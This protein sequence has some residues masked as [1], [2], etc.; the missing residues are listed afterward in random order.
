MKKFHHARLSIIAVVLGLS[1]ASTL[2]PVSA[3]ADTPAAD[4]KASTDVLRPEISKPLIAAKA[5]FDAKNI[6]D[7]IA[8]IA[9]ADAV[10]N[11]TPFEIFAVERTRGEYYMAAGDKPKAIKAF[12]AV[13]ASNYLKRADQLNMTQLI[14][15][16]DFQISDYPSTILWMNRYIKD[17]GTDPRAQDI[18]NKAHF[19]NKDYAEAY[20]GVN[21]QVQ[22]EIAAGV[23]PSEQNLGILLNC[24]NALND[25]DGTLNAIVQLTT[26]YPSAKNWNYLVSQ[27]H[28]KPGFSDKLFLDIYRLKVELSLMKTAADYADMSELAQRA[29]LP[30]EAKKALDLGF[31]AGVL[32]KGPEAKKYASQQAAAN[33][34]AADDLKTMQQGEA[35]A[36]SSKEGNGLINLG[37][38]FATAGQFDK[39][40]SL[41]EQ[42]ISKGGVSRVD[43]AKLHLGLVY[44]W[45]GKKEEALKQLGTVTGS[46]GTAELAKYWI[47]QI[48]HPLSK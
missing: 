48:N 46:D 40:A 1:A 10:E 38:A 17:G 30:A 14:G 29:G 27:I 12:E 34:R 16:I 6:P 31:A 23:T 47:M 37:M 9:E 36:N 15:Q 21:A 32:D 26:Y 8:K 41:I 18:L 35:G 3:Y 4:T 13:I 11:K 5:L 7:A 19:L 45:A 20:K 28:T 22:A 24:M 42:G 43:E 33:K 2:L 44:Y 39:G 25:K